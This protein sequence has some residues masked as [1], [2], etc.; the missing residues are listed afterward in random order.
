LD[1]TK[2]QIL[3]AVYAKPLVKAVLEPKLHALHASEIVQFQTYSLINVLTNA[4]KA[5]SVLME[6]V[7][8]VSH[9]VDY[10]L[11]SQRIVIRAMELV[12]LNLFIIRGAMQIVQ[13]DLDLILKH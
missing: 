13:R 1:N 11:E 4:L 10:V 9:P 7:P 8:N 2:V 5:I 6:F 12:E 3:L